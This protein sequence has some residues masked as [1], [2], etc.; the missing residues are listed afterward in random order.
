LLP[1][2][3]A[4]EGNVTPLRGTDIRF[5]GNSTLYQKLS[6][7]NLVP[8]ITLAAGQPVSRMLFFP[9]WAGRGCGANDPS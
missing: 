7:L 2:A 1:E 3:Q 6:L 5:R 4:L 8:E 9:P